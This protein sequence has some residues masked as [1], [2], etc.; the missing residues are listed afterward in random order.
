MENQENQENQNQI[1]AV[2]AVAH[3]DTGNSQVKPPYV[4]FLL[5]GAILLG[6]LI[7]SGTI[8]YTRGSFG[9]GK[10]QI[11]GAGTVREEKPVQVKLGP[12]E[13]ML[14]NPNAKV[15]I[16]EFSDF[17]CPFCRRFWADALPQIKKEYVDTGK[18]KFIYKH[19]PL[20]FHPGAKPAAEASECANE[21]GKFW[22]YHDKIFA[23][24]AKQGQGTIQFGKPELKNWASQIGL[25]TSQFNQCLDSGKYFKLIEDSVAYGSEIGVSG[26]PTTFING[27]RLVGAQPFVSFKAVID[28]LLK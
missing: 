12:N 18:A 6:A 27:Q 7:I 24:Q 15:T 3:T 10:A 19:Y 16:V 25:N 26:T 8:F 22:E 21:Q 1:E 4:H 23:E 14:G 9:V 2:P 5:P 11:G 17:Q 20:S 13:H 28:G